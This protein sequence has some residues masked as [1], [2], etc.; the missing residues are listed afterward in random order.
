MLELLDKKSSESPTQSE[1]KSR[2][3][4]GN[5]SH[6]TERSWT[7]CQLHAQALEESAGKEV[8]RASRGPGTMDGGKGL[9]AAN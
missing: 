8:S 3:G 1:G 6:V 2:Q 7:V 4:E 9:L 5:R